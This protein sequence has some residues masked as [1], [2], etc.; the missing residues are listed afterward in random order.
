MTTKHNRKA[1]QNRTNSRAR[2]WPIRSWAGLPVTRLTVWAAAMRSWARMATT[3]LAVATAPNVIYGDA[4]ADLIDG[5][6]DDD[7]LFGGVGDDTL[8]G[9]AGDDDIFSEMGIVNISGGD[10][11]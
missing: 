6:A 4:G 2:N 9:G 3:S 10:A 7:I 5:G 11:K 1:R 8:R